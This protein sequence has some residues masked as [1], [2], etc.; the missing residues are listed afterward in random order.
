MSI[1]I[2][3]IIEN[4]FAKNE[5]QAAAIA[6]GLRL[7]DLQYDLAAQQE[8]VRLYRAWR[9]SKTFKD[10]ASCFS[11]AILGERVPELFVR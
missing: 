1:I 6:N 3:W 5:F 7:A 10:T 9:D 2:N 11:K 4:K 8:R